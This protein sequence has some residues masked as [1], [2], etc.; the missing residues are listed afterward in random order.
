MGPGGIA[1]IIAACALFII[2]IALSYVVIR[3]GRFIDEAKLS[4][5]SLTD[6][7]APLIEEVHTTVTLVNGPL[8]SINKISKNAEDISEKFTEATNSFM[9]KNGSA[10]K[11]AG[12]LLSAA[13]MSKSRSKKKAE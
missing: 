1:T 6:E 12:A 8:K 7:T 2:A 10:V 13:S 5:K 9:N 4:L 11:I 3:V